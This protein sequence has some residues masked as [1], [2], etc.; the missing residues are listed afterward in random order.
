MNCKWRQRG[1]DCQQQGQQGQPQSN[2]ETGTGSVQSG[3]STISFSCVVVLM[4]VPCWALKRGQA[5]TGPPS[6]GYPCRCVAREDRV[7]GR[8][9]HKQT[10]VRTCRTRLDLPRE[11][12]FSSA[13]VRTTED[14]RRE[15]RTKHR[16]LRYSAVLTRSR[17]LPWLAVVIFRRLDGTYTKTIKKAC[18]VC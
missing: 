9:A 2:V 4:L 13:R 7:S 12:L 18:Q 11:L 1:L 17:G 6:C 16:T 3:H 14:K 15:Q 5:C 8:Q 10:S